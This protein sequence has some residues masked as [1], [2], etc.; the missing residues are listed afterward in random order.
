LTASSGPAPRCTDLYPKD[1]LAADAI[2]DRQADEFDL[3]REHLL[4]GYRFNTAR[5]YWGDLEHW[6][7]WCMDLPDA[8]DPLWP[9]SSDIEH[10]LLSMRVAGY[11]PNTVARR[12]TTLRAF[13]ADADRGG[14]NA[15]MKVAPVPRRRSD[16]HD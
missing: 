15:V 5:A 1:S 16:R 14:S 13:F 12:L 6:R 3:A 7:D 10:Y 11:S 2:E 4:L 8:V 9:T